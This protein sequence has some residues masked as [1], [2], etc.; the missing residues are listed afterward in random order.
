MSTELTTHWSEH[1]QS[2]QTILGLLSASLWVFD[3]D[4][5]RLRLER[6]ENSEALRK[7]LAGDEHNQVRI[8][9]KNVEPFRRNSPR[10]LKL[11][12]TYP[13]QMSVVQCPEH[14]FSLNDSLFIVDNRHA[15]IRFHKDNARSRVIIDD[16]EACAPY[17]TRFDEITKE[18]GEAISAT[19]L[20]L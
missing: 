9:L 13:D 4:L 18:G 5:T 3:E 19:T 10:L 11:L 6:P 12:A 7:C 8:V 15:L 17:V 20:G 1:D 14:L 2:L 16:R